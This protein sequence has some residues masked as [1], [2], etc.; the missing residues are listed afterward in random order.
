MGAR[1]K[2]GKPTKTEKTARTAKAAKAA[3]ART[4]GKADK[5]GKTASGEVKQVAKPAKTARKVVPGSKN[6]APSPRKVAVHELD[7]LKK[8]GQRTRVQRFFRVD[9]IGD[10]TTE[11][12]LV[13]FDH[14]GWYC[15]HGAAC[16]A[17]AD[18]RKAV[19]SR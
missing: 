1:G 7:P 12:H 6:G 13:F 10:R 9:V 18:V 15:E 16:Q 17:V 5:P 8:I 4:A 14:H 3:E 19:R 2:A 11:R